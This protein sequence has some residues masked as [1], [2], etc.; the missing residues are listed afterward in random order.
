[1]S[2]ATLG[3]ACQTNMSTLVDNRKFFPLKS[4]LYEMPIKVLDIK[5]KEQVVPQPKKESYVPYGG[6]CGRG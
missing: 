4:P 5:R 1:M 6:C 2:Y 3:Q